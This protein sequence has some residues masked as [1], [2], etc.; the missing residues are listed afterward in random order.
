MAALPDERDLAGKTGVLAQLSRNEEAALLI[1]LT[2][3]GVGKQKAHFSCLYD[4]QRVI[5]IDNGLP[6]RLS[7]YGQAVVK[8]Q[9]YIEGASQFVAQLGRHEQTSFFVD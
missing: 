5:F 2:F 3:G 9:C 8:A 6:S 1:G 7:I 4:R